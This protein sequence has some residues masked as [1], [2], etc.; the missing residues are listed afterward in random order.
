[1]AGT[2]GK[3]KALRFARV[4]RILKLARIFRLSRIIQRW[5]SQV[6]VSYSVMAVTKDLLA[7][8]MLTHW[9]ACFWYL[10]G[11]MDTTGDN[12][13]KAYIR[14]YPDSPVAA[15]QQSPGHIYLRSLYNSVSIM[16]R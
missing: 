12:W 7:L 4:M 10:A 5:E 13:I 9:G 8:L 11:T 2:G 15:N 16:V 14:D 3:V 1:M 6:G